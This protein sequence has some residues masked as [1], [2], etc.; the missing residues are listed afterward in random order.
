MVVHDW[1]P[2]HENNSIIGPVIETM[3]SKKHGIS[4][5]NDSSK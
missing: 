5:M 2:E 4:Q 1:R 3:N